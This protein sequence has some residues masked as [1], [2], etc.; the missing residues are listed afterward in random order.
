MSLGRGRLFH[1]V[2][3]VRSTRDSRMAVS[4]G[5]CML[6]TSGGCLSVTDRPS[7]GSTIM[8]SATVCKFNSNN[9]ELAAKGAIV[10]GTLRGGV[11][12]CGRARTTVIFGAKCITGMTAVSTVIGGKSA[13]FDSRLGRTDVVSK[14]HLS[15]T[16]VMACTRGSV[17]SLQGGVRRGPYRANVII[18][19]TIFSVSKSV[20]GLP[21]FLSVYRRGRLFSVMSRTRSAKIVNGANRKVQRC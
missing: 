6:V 10:R 9:S 11:T 16:G 18:D 14:Y 5:S 20:L 19:S 15:G 13:I 8:R 17:S 1:A 21:R 12:S 3:A 7:V 2:G 4:K